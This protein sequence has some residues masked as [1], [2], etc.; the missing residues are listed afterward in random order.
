MTMAPVEPGSEMFPGLVVI[1]HM[2]RGEDLDAY[3]CWSTERYSRCFVK[4]LRPD[5]VASRGPR[6]RLL[7][8]GRL[9]LSFTH[10][11]LV[12]AYDLVDPGSAAPPALV[13][14]T[15]TG[16]TLSH[17]LR[18]GRRL[19]LR[20]LA[21]LGRHLCSAIRY[22]HDHGYLHLDLKPSNVIAEGGRARVIDLSLAR[23]P[24]RTRGGRGTST[25][26][27]PE[28]ARG[29]KLGSAA[30]VWGV[31]L[32]LY[33]AATGHRPFDDE[34]RTSTSSPTY[35]QLVTT[36]PRTRTLRRLPAALSSTLDACLQIP[37]GD[38]PTLIELD[39]CLAS[40][41]GRLQH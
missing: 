26:M 35:P 17:L 6:R 32:L 15:L 7:R 31:G 29:G 16:A 13:L 25:H 2:R 38:R 19:S 18:G 22:L 8:E 40:I 30:D 21:F 36:A 41:T 23:R 39:D 28:Q 34:R 20:E 14:E 33:E 37:A 3:D 9:L 11:H 4:T 10:P 5:R 24:G 27:S 12:R 1:E